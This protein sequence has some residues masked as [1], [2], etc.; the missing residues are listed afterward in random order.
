VHL[1]W[2]WWGAMYGN[3][4]AISLWTIILFIWHHLSL[5]KHITTEHEKSRTH[6]E[7]HVS[8]HV[9]EITLPSERE[10]R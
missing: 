1:I 2:E 8:G 3:V 5:K 7:L 6:L 9:P 4:F 10:V